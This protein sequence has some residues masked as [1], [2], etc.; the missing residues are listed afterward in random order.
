MRGL[1]AVMQSTAS[2]YLL[3][4]TPSEQAFRTAFDEAPFAFAHALHL[5]GYFT[6]DA[7]L[8]LASRVSQKANRWYIEEGDTAPKN[9]WGARSSD[10]TLIQSLEGIATNRSLVMLKRVHEDPEYQEILTTLE[11][12]LSRLTGTD[13]AARYRDGL[14]TVL[15][16]SPHR[17]TPYH[18][19]GETNLL[20][21]MMGTKSV[22][23][24]DGNDREILPAKELEGFWSGDIKA[25]VYKEHLQDRA[26]RFEL[27]PGNGVTNP[28]TFPHW[29]QNGPEVS[30]SLSVN[31]KR[32]L[33]NA[34]DAYRINKQLRRLGV[35]PTDPGKLAIV[36]QTKGAVY[37]TARRL[38]HRL[39]ARSS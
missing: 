4:D 15:I 23:I 19:D 39:A 22:Y 24:F 10:S 8:R 35:Q 13:M 25:P 9:G 14:M 1:K 16:T 27:A 28:V 26:S 29:V 32:I 18:I 6:L 11:Q 33:D 12:E 34:A 3:V 36:D 17:V 20:M 7:L 31:F 38:K 21:Q 30:I 37:R 5:T 2:S